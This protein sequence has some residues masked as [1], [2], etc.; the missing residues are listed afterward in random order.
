MKWD[1]FCEMGD[2]KMQGGEAFGGGTLLCRAWFPSQTWASLQAEMEQG[3][4][5][6]PRAPSCPQD[7]L[8][9][10]P[11][12]W[13]LLGGLWAVGLR[14][15][16]GAGASLPAILSL[17]GSGAA[18]GPGMGQGVGPGVCTMEAGPGSWGRDPSLGP[19]RVPSFALWLSEFSVVIYVNCINP[20]NLK[21]S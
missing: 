5:F 20:G 15:M 16:V 21:A 8:S 10:S 4:A 14:L 17:P 2:P 12:P 13:S 18:W 6:L 7:R 3:L 9:Q 1:P 19:W 11:L